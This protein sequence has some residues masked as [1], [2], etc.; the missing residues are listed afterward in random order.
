MS[1][2]AGAT[3]PA[4]P[5]SAMVFLK[6]AMGFWKG[7]QRA[8]AWLWTASALVLVLANLAV[9][10]GINRWNK[11]F[12]THPAEAYVS[13]GD[14]SRRVPLCSTGVTHLQV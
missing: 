9:T 14:F 4:R 5:S 10:V 3:T 13:V 2:A 12:S 8:T 1:D 7:P 11:W 6:R